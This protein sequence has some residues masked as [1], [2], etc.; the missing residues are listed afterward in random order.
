MKLIFP[1][2]KIFKSHYNNNSVDV[3]LKPK[4]TEKIDKI[5]LR[6]KNNNKNSQSARTDDVVST[7][8]TRIELYDDGPHNTN[9]D[10]I[11][12]STYINYL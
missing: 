4:R 12:Y 6:G 2:V 8:Q 5:A 9:F 1:S 3:I 7:K 11:L 10:N